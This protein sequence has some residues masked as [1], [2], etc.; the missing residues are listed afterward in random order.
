MIPAGFVPG[1]LRSLSGPLHWLAPWAIDRMP[2]NIATYG[3]FF[4]LTALDVI[5]KTL[6][7]VRHGAVQEDRG[8]VSHPPIAQR[9]GT[10]REM[11]AQLYPEKD[12]QNSIRAALIPA[13]TLDLLWTRMME[14]AGPWQSGR[15]LHPMWD[16]L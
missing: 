3:A 12:D 10:M 14:Q 5:R 6:D 7:V 11:Y 8:F 4:V 1:W 13:Q 15:K 9:L 16:T 2:A